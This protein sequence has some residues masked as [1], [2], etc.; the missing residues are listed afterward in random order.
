MVGRSWILGALFLSACAASR[1][2][3]PATP[4]IQLTAH[5]LELEDFVARPEKITAADIAAICQEAGM[6]AVRRNRS[7]ARAAARGTQHPK[8]QPQS[9]RTP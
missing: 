5:R 7:A 3:E 8:H 1:H 6:Q 9:P 4:E 2:E